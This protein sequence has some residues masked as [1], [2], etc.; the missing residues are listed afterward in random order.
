MSSSAQI[1]QT[2]N[3]K[4]WRSFKW[5]FR[6]ILMLV[7]SFLFILAIAIR[8]GE[9][10]SLP[11]LKSKARAYQ[12]ALSP[13]NPLT[14]STSFEKKYNGF[15]QFLH[16]KTTDNL[17]GNSP[18]KKSS[19]NLTAPE[20]RAAFYTPWAATTSLPDLKKYADKLNVIF[21][22]WF[23]ID[24][25]TQKLQTR[26]DSAGLAIMRQKGLRII[27][28]LTNFNS[29]KKDFDG[30]LLHKILSDQVKQKAFIRQLQDTLNYYH[31]QGIN[32]DFEDLKEKTNEPLTLFQK[33]LYQALHA[34]N[35]LVTMDVAVRNEDYD[36]AKLSDYND[37]I[38]LMAYDQHDLS[39]NAG[40]VSEQQ[41]IESSLDWTANRIKPEKI[42]LGIAGYGYEWITD[43]AGKTTARVI[44][45]NDA[46]NQARANEVEI[47]FDNHSYNPHYSYMD[48]EETDDGKQEHSKHEV[49]FIDAATTFNTLRFSDE[50]ATAGTALWR[51]GGEDTRMWNFYD[52]DLSNDALST[53]PFD[54]SSLT[55]IPILPDN[56][57]YDGEGEVLNIIHLPQAG[58]VRFE[59][60]T[61]EQLISEQV[62]EQ[63]PSGYI[64]Q[65]FAE[66]T[67]PPGPGHK[68]I[69]TFDDGP[70]P[71]W[72]PQI[73][74]I[75]EKEKVPASFFVVGLQAEQNIPLIQRINRDGFEI[76]NH[77]FTH[78]N[79]AKMSPQR[80]GIE[81]KL[82]RL[83]IESIT[84]RSTILFRAPYNADSEPHT[85]EEL[86][87]IELSRSQNYLTIGESIDPMDWQPG[88]TAD[89][90]VARTIEQVES[91][92][93]SIILLHDAGGES[94]QATIDALPKIIYYFK[95]KGYKFTTVAGL[96]GKTKNDVMPKLPPSSES[97]LTHINFLFAEGTYWGSHILFTLFIIGILLSV[98]RMLAMAILAALQKRKESKT[99]QLTAVESPLVSVIIPAY[100]EEVNALRTITS[101]LQQDYP[102]LE[103]IFIDDGSRDKTYETV[104]NEFSDSEM[105]QVYTKPNGGK[106]SA[107]NMGIS[108]ATGEFVVCIDA[109]TQ[110]RKDAI[111]Q[112][113]KKFISVKG[114]NS[115]SVAEWDPMI[116]AVAGNVKVGNE[117][118]MITRWQSIEYITSQNLDRRAFDLLNCIT[119]V[120]G[121]IGAFRKEAVVK[122]GGFTM[123]TLA[124]D[125]DLT[126]RLHRLG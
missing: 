31:F 24:T 78:N 76:G 39:G 81:L 122:A 48:E 89:S 44:T 96:M 13:N 46:I 97:W 67:T 87:P 34:D 28:L 62:Y 10:P 64:I 91:R 110:L 27:P 11:N 84:G 88:V 112:L 19:S 21:P 18:V 102:N 6:I 65:R 49:W 72:T 47:D 113:M 7:A 108:K 8:R 56:V 3:A 82:T 79:V 94:R 59:I 16:K 43:E 90:I 123:D 45:Y 22:E 57:A 36:Y 103:V 15:K 125:C 95:T 12:I 61:T 55:T 32:I 4:R 111:S 52:Q 2:T 83:L 126:M 73:L 20:I 99:V 54:F 40:P 29:S 17:L 23:F 14:L 80:A 37:Y 114:N 116:A 5:S 51:L 115:S 60:D 121:A 71:E 70:D 77:T 9:N 33:E 66:D 104:L 92:G 120:P 85:Y 41:W 30:D 119:V 118:N 63:L 50:F 117:V 38:V 106:A 74:D 105:V 26:I 68:L 53:R 98:G 86:E 75:L 42:I 93:A 1:F 58:K 107:L 69:L 100:N 109:D 124:E 25:L 35:M 101:L